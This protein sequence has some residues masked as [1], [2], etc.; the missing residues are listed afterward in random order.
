MERDRQKGIKAQRDPG[1]RRETK[2]ERNEEQ[3][4]KKAAQPTP[5]EETHNV[6]GQNQRIHFGANNCR[7]GA[8]G[9]GANAPALTNNNKR[10][11][12]ARMI[13]CTNTRGSNMQASRSAKQNEKQR[14]MKKA[15]KSTQLPAGCNG[16]QKSCNHVLTGSRCP[17]PITVTHLRTYGQAFDVTRL[18]IAAWMS[19]KKDKRG[20]HRQRMQQSTTMTKSKQARHE[21]KSGMSKQ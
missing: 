8:K 14:E 4:T 20:K 7:Q 11:S 15:G 12:Q 5:A 16:A 13:T 10:E 21:T 18:Y 3:R 2:R 1:H 17:T 9:R 19:K 6:Q